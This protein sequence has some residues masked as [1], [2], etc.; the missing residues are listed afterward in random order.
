M[1]LRASPRRLLSR[2]VA[3]ASR[4]VTGATS[5]VKARPTTLPQITVTS[6]K[7]AV[8]AVMTRGRTVARR[9]G[10]VCAT[11]RTMASVPV[12]M[13]MISLRRAVRAGRGIS[14]MGAP[15][16]ALNLSIAVLRCAVSRVIW[17]TMS[18][19]AV[20]ALAEARKVV[21]APSFDLSSVRMALMLLD[22][23]VG[24]AA[25]NAA[26]ASAERA[27]SLEKNISQ[28]GGLKESGLKEG[29]Y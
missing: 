26:N 9:A 23:G 4:A 14:W 15:P 3:A 8:A 24:A 25:L 21:G 28:R 1:H 29:V 22:E 2:A 19:W 18:G 20:L 6:V 7:S 12:T 16:M 5:T 13:L 11:S 17:D 10:T 27:A